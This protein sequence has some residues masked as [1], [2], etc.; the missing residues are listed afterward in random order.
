MLLG[1]GNGRVQRLRCVS[2]LMLLLLL[3]LLLL[4]PACLRL[5]DG[6]GVLVPE[7]MHVIISGTTNRRAGLLLHCLSGGKGGCGKG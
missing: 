7:L 6:S 2:G 4:L 1:G 3:L 5:D